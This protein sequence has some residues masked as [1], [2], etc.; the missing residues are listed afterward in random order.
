MTVQKPKPETGIDKAALHQLFTTGWALVDGREAIRKEFLFRNFVE[1]FGFMTRAAIWA[2]KLNHHPEWSN[3]YRT[4]TV[5]L[6]THDTNG[7]TELDLKLARKMDELA[8]Y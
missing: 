5:E 8:G 7:L 4:V 3:V 1:A 2:E 6:I